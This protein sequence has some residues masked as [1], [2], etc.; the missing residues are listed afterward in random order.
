LRFDLEGLHMPN[1][2]KFGLI[3]GVSLV[4]V[5]A[6]V[7]FRK[8]LATAGSP[9]D[10]NGPS[11]A[12]PPSTTLPVPPGGS[13]RDAKAKVLIQTQEVAEATTGTRYHTVREGDT[14]FGLAQHYYG[15]GDKFIEIYRVN[16]KVLRSPDDLPPGTVL[17]IPELQ[18]A[19]ASR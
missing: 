3:L 1:A 16:R 9:T 2:A 5:I 8:D 6:A 11:A 14:L 18:G 4:I 15:D 10:M 12:R 17:I 19:V 13:H 7:F